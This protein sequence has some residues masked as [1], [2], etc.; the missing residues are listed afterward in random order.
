M[1]CHAALRGTRGAVASIVSIDLRRA[2]LAWLGVGN[3]SGIVSRGTA[4]ALAGQD[5]LLARPGVIGAGDLPPLQP[6]V[7]ALRARDTL[8]LATDGVRRRHCDGLPPH[9]PPQALA[10]EIVARHCAGNDDA[11]VVVARAG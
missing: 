2:A 7:V 8:I 6:A 5:E 11:L 9:M 10:E 1:R 4:D 3:V